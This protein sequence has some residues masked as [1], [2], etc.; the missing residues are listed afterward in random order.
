MTRRTCSAGILLIALLAPGAALCQQPRISVRQEA[1][2]GFVNAGDG[3]RLFY[4]AV[5]TAP[6]TLVVVHGGP[7]FDMEY[8]AADLEPLADDLT[9]I[10]YDQ[11]GMGR[12]TLVRDSAALAATAFADDLE[13]IRS[14]FGLQQLDILGHSWGAGVA[15]LYATRYPDQVD[16][17]VIVSGLPL[18]REPLVTGFRAM[19]A[20]RDS[21]EI[22]RMEDLYAALLADPDNAAACRNYYAIW[23]RPF[24]GVPGAAAET[25]GDFCAAPGEAR[26][27]GLAYVDRYTLASLGEWD[28]RNAL[29][30]MEAPALI[31]HGTEDPIPFRAAQE[32][33]STLPNSR[34]L[35]LEGIGH[36]PYLE[37]PARFF[38]SVTRFVTGEH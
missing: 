26:A 19:Q 29:R 7:G 25:R 12:S 36:F 34:L 9:L 14:H 38:P 31:I 18:H 24:F 15:A 6:D 16:R 20:N 23:F 13:A 17:L 35:M 37:A 33:S 30:N 21:S 32:W 2:E 4:R 3:V 10:F 1:D 28:W 22:S 11:R 27:N 5:G 8:F